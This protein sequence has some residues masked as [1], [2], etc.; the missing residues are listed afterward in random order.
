[1]FQ[2]SAEVGKRKY[3]AAWGRNKKEAEQRAAENALSEMKGDE[4]PNNVEDPRDLI[5]A[6]ENHQ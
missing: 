4:P 3:T 2:I 1:M 6:T 5:P